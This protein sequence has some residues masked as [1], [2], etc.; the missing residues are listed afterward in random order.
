MELRALLTDLDAPSVVGS[1]D[2]EIR[3]IAY[4]S[5]EVG[6]GFLFAALR[7]RTFDGQAFIQEAVGRGAVAVLVD[8]PVGAPP[9]VTLVRVAEAR[10]ALA[11]VTAAF[12]GHPSRRLHLIGVTG[13]NGK[14][15]TTYLVEAIL[16][17]AGRPCGII[18]TM[19]LVTGSEV[20]PTART[21]PEA[22]D[23]QAALRRMVDRGCQ[24]V[25]M[26][27]ASH[28]LAQERVTGCQFQVG[29]F[30]NLTRDHLDFH[31]SMEAY[32]AAK[33]RL[34]AMLP[35]EGWAVLNADDPAA[36]V[37]RAVSPAR[38]LTYGLR[39]PADVR[40]R[41][42]RLHL[43]GSE[44]VA[45]TPAGS[46]AVSLRLAGGFN[47]ANAL[48]AVAVGITQGIPLP[49]IARA[50]ASVPGI[51]GRFEAVDEG[52]PFAVVVDY[53]HTP[54][55]LDNVLRSARELTGGRLIVVFGCGGDRDRLKRPVMGRIAAKW[56]DHVIVTSDN[57]RSEDPQAIIEEIRPGVESGAAA[58]ASSGGRGPVRVDIDPD[59][60][61]AIAVAIAAAR[62]GDLVV[63]AGKGHET[64]QEIAG[65]KHPFDDRQVVR[66][67]LR[68]AGV[69]AGR[70]RAAGPPVRGPAP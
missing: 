31:R 38:L 52:Q 23:L 67:A 61:R 59:R 17:A 21:T 37:M 58:R 14:G 19:G 26:E 41:D 64:Y 7:G 60:R 68:A 29:V 42:V 24:Y 16:R 3:G 54:D 44:F 49:T 45:D 4:D 51:P 10:R 65:V 48:A 34:F 9:G 33:V 11:Q 35:P 63:V 69:A 55:G 30:T 57:P 15:A 47:V 50:L 32:R 12:F 70:P 62:P 22:P 66:E 46:I 2:R 6:P 20:V 56:A 40:G 8:R 13:T 27:V 36:P 25:A 53:A 5:R 39:T 18:G 28:A 1:V 43:A